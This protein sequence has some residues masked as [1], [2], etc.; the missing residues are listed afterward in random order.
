ME[1]KVGD[2]YRNRTLAYL[3]PALAYYGEDFKERFS[4]VFKLAFGIFDY[5]LE[6]SHLQGQKNLYI[7][8]DREFQKTQYLNFMNWIKNQEFYV[9]DY[10]FDNQETGRLQMLVIAF[11]TPLEDAYDKFLQGKYSEMYFKK[12][13]EDLFSDSWKAETKGVLTRTIGARNHFVLKVKEKWDTDL[14]PTDFKKEKYE[15]DFPPK[16]EKEIFNQEPLGV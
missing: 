8:L 7:L 6:E 12:E 14:T 11:P 1:L 5:L 4:T 15:Y 2:L 13:I 3:V 9:T 10:S 16:K